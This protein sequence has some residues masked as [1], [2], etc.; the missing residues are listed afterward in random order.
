[1]DWFSSPST[2]RFTLKSEQ[3]MDELRLRK[4]KELED[5]ERQR[6]KHREEMQRKREEREEKLTNVMNEEAIGTKSDEL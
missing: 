5:E 4:Q 2:T 1:M 3:E 6:V